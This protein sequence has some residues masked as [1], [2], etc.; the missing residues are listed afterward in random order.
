M[1]KLFENDVSLTPLKQIK[2]PKGDVYHA[3]K[4]TEES[5]SEFGEAYFSTV[6]CNEVKGWKK[7]K[8]MLMNL[9]VPVGS[10]RFVL[11]DERA[12]SCSRGVFSEVTLSPD[13]YCRLT[14]PPG[15]WMAFQGKA[16]DLNLVLNIASIEHEPTEAE[17]VDIEQFYYD[18]SCEK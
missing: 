8:K 16:E 6:I 1:T 13:N 12:D 9:V 7:H 10:V 18:W 3:L 4:S 11:F 5:F 15:I 17:N 14:V 2:N